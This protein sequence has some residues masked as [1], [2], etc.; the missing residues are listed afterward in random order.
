MMRKYLGEGFGQEGTWFW[1]NLPRQAMTAIMGSMQA[2]WPFVEEPLLTRWLRE[3]GRRSMKDT[4]LSWMAL[5]PY[6]LPSIRSSAFLPRP[7]VIRM[8]AGGVRSTM[9]GQ[10]GVVTQVV[11]VVTQAVQVVTPW[12]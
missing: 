2:F 11:Q 4:S 10:A 8:A 1:S 3:R 12:S 6:L 7:W 9:V 5:L